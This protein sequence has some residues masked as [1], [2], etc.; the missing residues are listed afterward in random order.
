[1]PLNPILG[2]TVA[3]VFTLAAVLCLGGIARIRSWPAR[4]NVLLTAVMNSALAVAAVTPIPGR[5]VPPLVVLQLVAALWF[6]FQCLPW[7][8]VRISDIG[9]PVCFY[10]AVL[11]TLTASILASA[12]S[13]S[14][15]GQAGAPVHLLG[16]ILLSAFGA[17]LLIITAVFWLLATFATPRQ[18]TAAEPVRR[19][20]GLQEAFTAAGLAV[21]LFALF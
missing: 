14:A 10:R 12:A 17:V 15:L 8:P 4:V 5:A 9:R 1:M 6:L 18:D 7:R 20:Q 19:L 3:V 13:V 16:S 11:L 21:F 2:P